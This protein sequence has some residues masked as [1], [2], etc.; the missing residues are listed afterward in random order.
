M[1]HCRECAVVAE[2]AIDGAGDGD[3]HRRRGRLHHEGQDDA[4]D[5]EEDVGEVALAAEEIDPR[6]DLGRRGGVFLDEV[7]EVGDG[8]LEFTQADEEEAEAEQMENTETAILARL[9]FNCPYNDAAQPADIRSL[10]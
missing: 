9:G 7:L 6:L 3:G 4:S 1:L 5:Q 8:V 10:A 2:P